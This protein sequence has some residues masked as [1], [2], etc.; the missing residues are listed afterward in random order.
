[1]KTFSCEY[2]NT[3]VN[4]RGYDSDP[5]WRCIKGKYESCRRKK[6][7]IEYIMKPGSH[8]YSNVEHLPLIKG[9]YFDDPYV[10]IFNI[11]KEKGLDFAKDYALDH[12]PD[13][14]VKHWNKLESNLRGIKEYLDSKEM[15]IQPAKDLHKNFINVPQKVHDWIEN[16]NDLEVRSLLLYGKPGTGKTQLAKSIAVELNRL[17]VMVTGS[18]DSLRSCHNDKIGTLIFDDIDLSHEKVSREEMIA[19]LDTENE[20]HIRVRYS[21]IRIKAGTRK[22]FVTNVPDQITRSDDALHRRVTPVHITKTLFKK[23]PDEVCIKASRKKTI[24]EN[25]ELTMKYSENKAEGRKNNTDCVEVRSFAEDRLTH[26][27]DRGKEW[28]SILK[29]V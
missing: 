25:I 3:R 2:E 29:D 10:H 26:L 19:I 21:N 4:T 27:E 16:E 14:A 17:Y 24:E 13:M 11:C 15:V 7:T 6:E 20:R 1:V 18:I 22:I 12:Y 9:T 28:D 23:N 5:R 8:V